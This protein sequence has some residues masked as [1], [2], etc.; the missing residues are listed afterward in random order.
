MKNLKKVG[1]SAL[2]GSL[3]AFS[4]NAV[5]MS[6]SGTAEVTYTTTGGTNANTGN[7]WGSNTSVK[8]SGSGDVGFGTATIVRTLNDNIGAA[9]STY[10]TLDMGDM[11]TLSFDA[12][13]GGLEGTV[14]NDDLLP[15][16]YEEVWTGVA[17]AGVV[18]AASNDTIGYSNTFAGVSISLAQTASYA[19]GTAGTG[20]GGN[21]GEGVTASASD[22]HL[23]YDIP[24][25]DGLTVKYGQSTIDYSLATENDDTSSV[26]HILYSTGPVSVGYKMAEFHDGSAGSNGTNIEAY[27]IAFNVSDEMKI[28]IATQDREFDVPSGTNVTETSDAI[29][30]SYTMGAMSVRGT[31]AESKDTAGQT[32]DNDEHME[33]SLVLAF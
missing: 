22:W 12:N 8:F 14:A 33:L 9:L 5:E 6:V 26:G 23:S 11:G 19:G 27:A 13:G 7:P 30:A 1:L 18:G 2:A 32:G 4:A 28:S 10:Q 15:T 17:G 16:A 3:V 24:Y 21:D 25:V 31:F 20:D 29:N